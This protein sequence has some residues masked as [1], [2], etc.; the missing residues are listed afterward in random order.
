[1]NQSQVELPALAEEAILD[2][3]VE[4]MGRVN[5]GRFLADRKGITEKVQ[6]VRGQGMPEDV[7]N[8]DIFNLPMQGTNL[9]GLKFT[10]Q[11]ATGPAF[12]R[13]RFKLTQ[14]GDTFLDLSRWQ[15]GV[16]WVNGHNLGR[17]WNLGP[18]QTLYCP[19]PWL[20]VGENE[21][22]VLELLGTD[23]PMVAGVAEP[24]LNRLQPSASSAGKVGAPR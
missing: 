11:A 18:Q 21:V 12:Y 17:Y 4:A 19:G 9:A 22:I 16:V 3:L 6:L 7:L 23:E 20:K 1:L 13:G 5:Y 2:I 24:I 10:K 15:K 8:W 14:L